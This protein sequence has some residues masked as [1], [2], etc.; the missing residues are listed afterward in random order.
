MPKEGGSGVPPAESQ[1]YATMSTAEGQAVAEK[2]RSKSKSKS[3]EEADLL[4]MTT[5]TG[6]ATVTPG[7]SV[8]DDAGL[9][10]CYPFPCF[11][12]LYFFFLFLLDLFFQTDDDVVS[13]AQV[14]PPP[15][16][17]T[18]PEPVEMVSMASG[19]GAPGAAGAPAETYAPALGAVEGG[20]ETGAAPAAAFSST[21]PT[22]PL[23]F[24]D[25]VTY[26]GLCVRA[27]VFRLF[28]FFLSGGKLCVM[29]TFVEH[30]AP[31]PPEQREG[32]ADP[33]ADAVLADLVVSSANTT[34]SPGLQRPKTWAEQREERKRRD[35]E[36]RAGN[37][38]R[39]DDCFEGS[40]SFSWRKKILMKK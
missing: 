12:C 40:F 9:P 2:S 27:F 7:G 23:Y 28:V 1:D 34:Y 5:A 32:F 14:V 25:Y 36:R 13:E 8:F 38:K 18:A 10:S 37:S 3:R 15:S 22:A 30:A 11:F 35:E 31:A 19:A 6:A 33:E 21:E 24:R 17:P 26:Y 16:A 20:Y 39:D 4:M 29:W